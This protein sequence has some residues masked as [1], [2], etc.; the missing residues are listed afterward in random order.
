M[1]DES[2]RQSPPS[3]SATTSMF[4]AAD[5]SDDNHTSIT[6]DG[7]LL[8]PPF[9]GLPSENAHEWYN[10]FVRYVKYKK[11]APSAALELFT[12]LL[13][14]NAAAAFSTLDRD[15]QSNHAKVNAWFNERYRYSPQRK[16]RL[17]QEL[18][19]RKQGPSET[20]DDYFV[21][22]QGLANQIND[23]PPDDITR[24]AIMSGLRPSIA[25]HVMAF[26]DKAA[27]IDELLTT[28]RA[29]EMMTAATP[30]TS[31]VQSLIDEV[32]RL[33]DRIDTTTT[34]S[35]SH[36]S[37]SPSTERRRVTFSDRSPTPPTQPA[38]NNYNR[39]DYNHQDN[40]NG[41]NSSRPVGP[42][43]PTD[44]YY[45]STRSQQSGQNNSRR[46]GNCARFH[47]PGRTN[48][49]AFNKSCHNCF[50]LHHIARCCRS[51]PNNTY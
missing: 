43:P 24:Y 51:R 28:A 47:A 25:G 23:R 8:P 3:K 46:C 45:N 12:V 48:C 29:A 20:V 37:R 39:N 11:L 26:A 9:F 21:A 31:V 2:A 30:D 40:N 41:Y 1:E 10:Y 42:A 18:F 38:R 34:R 49:F 32:K 15:V 19:M 36:Q 17:G 16:F 27:T 44:T 14:G 33:S 4:E 13:R 50:Q 6:G 22:I 35:V 5:L 7:A